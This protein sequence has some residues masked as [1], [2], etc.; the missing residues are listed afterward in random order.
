MPTHMAY[1]GGIYL[2]ACAPEMLSPPFCPEGCEVPHPLHSGRCERPAPWAAGAVV[3]G[4]HASLKR[5][6]KAR[7]KEEQGEAAATLVPGQRGD[8]AATAARPKP[9]PKEDGKKGKRP[10]ADEPLPLFEGPLA[11]RCHRQ[12]WGGGPVPVF[13]QSLSLAFH[14]HVHCHCSCRVATPAPSGIPRPPLPSAF[15]CCIFHMRFNCR[16]VGGT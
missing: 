11:G 4:K 5:L 7:S 16:L 3:T 13:P 15:L 8:G 12:E 6:L 1:S 14:C 2:H 9:K 10:E